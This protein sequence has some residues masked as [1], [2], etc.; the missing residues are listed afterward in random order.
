[1]STLLEVE[2]LTTEFRTERGVVHA[3]SD[4]SLTVDRSE[5]VGIVGESGSGKST[6]VR[7]MIQ[8]VRPPGKVVRGAVRFDGEDL[9]VLGRNAIRQFRGNRIGFIAQNPFGALN[10]V[11]RIKKQFVNVVAAHRKASRSEVY[12]L[13]T[14][15]LALT[16]IPDPERVLH[17]HAHELSGGMAQR[18]VIAMTLCLDPDLLIADEPTTALDLTVQRQ[19]LDTLHALT[20]D[21]GRSLL[22]VTHDLGVVDAYCDRVVVMYAGRVVEHGPTK[23]VFVHPSHPYTAAL[24]ASIPRGG[25]RPTALAGGP[26][27]LI[28]LPAGCPYAPRCSAAIDRCTHERP[29]QEPVTATQFAACHLPLTTGIEHAVSER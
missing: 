19:I 14:R 28:G 23:D 9:L 6:T 8:L 27:D 4:V 5:I 12:A 22:L 10:P 11:Y 29:E 26:P 13:A 1:M 16:G 20:R 18:V 24:L 2:G 7:S 3:V 25:V 21:Q 15:Q 17:G